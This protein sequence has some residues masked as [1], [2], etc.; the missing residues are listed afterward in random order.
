MEKVRV[1]VQWCDK[2]FGASFGEN[3]PGAVAFTA[4]TFEELMQEAEE[5]LRFHVEGMIEDGDEVPQWLREGDYELEYNY[6][7]VATM[8]RAC[9]SYAS[10]A[11][12][13]RATGINQNQL[14][15]YATGLK[16]PRPLQRKR[17][18]DGIHY[19]GK[20]LMDVV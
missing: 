10:L 13:S 7:D 20:R 9:E 5:T 19:I 4:K 1:D 17:I 3:V 11:A 2:N 6:V 14:S 8:L 12:I 16:R 18:V 15:H